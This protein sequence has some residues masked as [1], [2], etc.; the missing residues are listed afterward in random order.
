MNVSLIDLLGILFSAPSL[1]TASADPVNPGLFATLL[2]QVKAETEIPKPVQ[3][4]G[5]GFAPTVIADNAETAPDVIADDAPVEAVEDDE[6]VLDESAEPPE[7]TAGPPAH[8]HI[9]EVTLP[10]P[11][12]AHALHSN[13]APFEAYRTSPEPAATPQVDP[14]ANTG[15]TVEP[16]ARSDTPVKAVQLAVPQPQTVTSVE[17]APTAPQAA[18]VAQGQ[19]SAPPLAEAVR[20][21][22]PARPTVLV[23]ARPEPGPLTAAI[24]TVTPPDDGAATPLQPASEPNRPNA[25]PSVETRTAQQAGITTASRDEIEPVR[26]QGHPPPA[27]TVQP[28]KP[29]RT[30]APHRAVPEPA[31]QAGEGPNPVAEQLPSAVVAVTRAKTRE[32]QPQPAALTAALSRAAVTLETSARRPVRLAHVDLVSVALPKPVVEQAVVVSRVALPADKSAPKA[33]PP[34]DE[35]FLPTEGA[36]NRAVRAVEVLAALRDGATPSRSADRV[37][38]ATVPPRPATKSPAEASP[39]APERPV[40]APARPEPPPMPAAKPVEPTTVGQQSGA[41]APDAVE[42]PAAPNIVRTEG[43]APVAPATGTETTPVS[44]P[45]A[46]RVPAPTAS[47]PDRPTVVTEP[48]ARTVVQHVRHLT[49]SGEQ[50]VTVKLV[51]ESLGELHIT[52][53]S[54][55]DAVEVVLST[56]NQHVRQALEHQLHALRETLVR[57]GID[58]TKATVT[59]P[60][61]T[62]NDV[63]TAFTRAG[64]GHQSGGERHHGGQPYSGSP[65]REQD[66]PHQ[67]RRS[68]NSH[69]G[70]LNVFA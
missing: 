63:Q 26:P 15:K 33:P 69:Q 53:K 44:A 13:G 55:R 45:A 65:A 16:V 24:P 8:R 19:S 70:R 43:P 60:V 40:A 36:R 50:T 61:T 4:Q 9:P 49:A 30:W 64:G 54:A 41:A 1:G 47:A 67:H 7:K 17:A 34:A 37:E 52:V 57:E 62:D 27:E 48:V 5:E 32:L 11:A 12:I 38:A 18:P 3:D 21:A 28:A 14:A 2:R 6:P 56:S 31:S 59:M 39:P 20:P 23:Q 10:E 29:E 51:P 66:V 25:P 42:Q 35:A 58:V 46:E 22:V 68:W